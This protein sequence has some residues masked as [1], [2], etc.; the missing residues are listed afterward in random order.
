M[1]MMMMM[2]MMMNIL[3]R[4]MIMLIMQSGVSRDELAQAFSELVETGDLPKDRIALKV[5]A[6]E[7]ENWPFLD[8]SV[9]GR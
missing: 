9:S 3:L 2:M 1:M 6:Q 7:M 4:M 8:R 5:L